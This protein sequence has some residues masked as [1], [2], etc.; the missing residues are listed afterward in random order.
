MNA[1]QTLDADLRYWAVEYELGHI[2]RSARWAG[3]DAAFQ[4]YSHRIAAEEAAR[5]AAT[6]P[7]DAL[8]WEVEVSQ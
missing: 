5:Q 6:T 1:D 3:E 8:V 2:T 4:V 7:V